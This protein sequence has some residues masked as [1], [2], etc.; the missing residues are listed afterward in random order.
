MGHVKSL[1]ATESLTSLSQRYNARLF[2]V[3]YNLIGLAL[4]NTITVFLRLP[5]KHSQSLQVLTK[6]LYETLWDLNERSRDGRPSALN[7]LQ[8]T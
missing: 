7:T 5:R 3:P 6:R 4:V 1:R 2:H 8:T